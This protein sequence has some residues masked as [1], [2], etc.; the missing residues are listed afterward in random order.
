MT[1]VGPGGDLDIVELAVS[2]GFDAKGIVDFVEFWEPGIRIIEVRR[3]RLPMLGFKVRFQGW[4][5]RKTCRCLRTLGHWKYMGDLG[6]QPGSGP[7]QGILKPLDTAE[8]LLP[9]DVLVPD[10]DK[11]KVPTSASQDGVSST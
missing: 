3:I 2:L 8:R 10:E 4:P 11:P 1:Q 5:L 7:Y 6:P 9:G